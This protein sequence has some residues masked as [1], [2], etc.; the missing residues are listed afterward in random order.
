MSSVTLRRVQKRFGALQIIPQLD[1]DIAEHE[2]VTLV[3]PSGCGKST[4]L[5][6]GS[7]LV[8]ATRGTIHIRGQAVR[9]PFP[10]V[11]FLFQQPVLLPWRSVLPR[12]SI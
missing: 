10:D 4:L 7:G 2:F 3:G 8:P 9:E 6:L 1:L 12:I 5:K 11:G